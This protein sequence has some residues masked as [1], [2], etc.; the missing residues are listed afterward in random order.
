MWPQASAFVF[1]LCKKLVLRPHHWIFND[2]KVLFSVC[3]AAR[4][5]LPDPSAQ[6]M[7]EKL[8]ESKDFQTWFVHWARWFRLIRE[9]E[10]PIIDYT[11]KVLLIRGGQRQREHEHAG[12][13]AKEV[14]AKSSVR[15]DGDTI[16]LILCTTPG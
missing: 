16:I 11:W 15:E 12:Y 13:T 5:A 8:F 2:L 1:I 10:N 4:R 7:S 6:I 3:P 9:G 14:P